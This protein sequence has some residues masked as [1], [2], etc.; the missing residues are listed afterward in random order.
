MTKSS[1]VSILSG[2]GLGKMSAFESSSYYLYLGIHFIYLSR[3]TFCYQTPTMA[4]TASIK[5]ITLTHRTALTKAT[6]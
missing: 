6:F 5:Q 4:I 2:Q 3:I 1:P